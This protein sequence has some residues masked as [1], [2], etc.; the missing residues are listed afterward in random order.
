MAIPSKDPSRR[1]TIHVRLDEKTHQRLKILVAQRTAT[2]QELF[3]SLF[4]R[5][6]GGSGEQ[7]RLK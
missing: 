1:P 4:L 7:K 2:I 5:E 6:V 3:E